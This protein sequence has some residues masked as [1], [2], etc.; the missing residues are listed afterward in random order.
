MSIAIE[1][2]HRDDSGQNRASIGV[3]VISGF[4]KARLFS[5]N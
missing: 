2:S 3:N 5:W 4:V 1:L